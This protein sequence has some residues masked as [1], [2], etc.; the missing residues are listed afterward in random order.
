MIEIAEG[1]RGQVDSAP[2]VDGE[3]RAPWMVKGIES[4]CRERPADRPQNPP[5][6]MMAFERAMLGI[7]M[8]GSDP[9]QICSIVYMSM[10]NQGR[11]PTI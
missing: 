11:S 6:M 1:R 9:L 7:A 8:R 4:L 2:M 10:N 5:P 3:V